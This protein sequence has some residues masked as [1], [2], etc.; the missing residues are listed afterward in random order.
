[1]NIRENLARFVFAFVILVFVLLG[2]IG[3]AQAQ[4]IAPLST[5]KP[6]DRGYGLTVFR[7]VQPEKFEY[8]VKG[9]LDLG[10]EK[11][12]V[13]WLSGGPKING[14]DMLADTNIF[15]GMSGSPIFNQ[16]GKIIGAISRAPQ[17]EKKPIAYATPIEDLV[18]FKPKAFFGP[19]PW[20]EGVSPVG[21]GL[22]SAGDSF[23]WCEIWGDD[24]ACGGGTVTAIDPSNPTFAYTLGHPGNIRTNIMALPFW[25]TEII[26]LIPN[27][28]SSRKIGNRVGPM[29]GSVIFDGPF[30]QILKIGAMPKVIPIKIVTD[31]NLNQK[32]EA[33]I[34]CAY[35]LNMANHISV[36]ILDRKKFIVGHQDID[37]EIRI[38][39]KGL[40][41]IF[42]SGYLGDMTM[43][44]ILADMFIGEEL[45]T[46]I[47]SI[48]VIL[49]PRNKY[50]KLS[51][52]EVKA[53]TLSREGDMLNIEVEIKA[54][55]SPEVGQWEF[56]F[57]A[58]VNKKFI[59]KKI[60]VADG[61]TVLDKIAP[62]L[63]PTK[64]SIELLNKVSDRNPLYLFFT[65]ANISS[66]MPVATFVLNLSE[67]SRKPSITDSIWDDDDSV[68]AKIRDSTLTDADKDKK[69][70]N[71]WQ[72]KDNSSEILHKIDSPVAGYLIK[73]IKEFTVKAEEASTKNN[74]K[75][76]KKKILWLF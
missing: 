58:K 9:I 5:V 61:E 38:S 10:D 76:K 50:E 64:E 33:N 41:Q 45:K 20:V 59:D 39:P 67:N 32:T 22:I 28:M 48:S 54:G 65:D 7:G 27:V 21:Q 57:H 74:N 24:I 3:L 19:N 13:I 14:E 36:A 66:S 53:K 46:G 69:P 2:F 30:G 8:E 70:L 56:T 75:G 68:R 63:K 15:A 1:M 62:S 51:L 44:G 6:G 40:P 23:A 43:A 72:K 31:G 35:T 16:G 34:F 29:L 12:I 26:T 17:G 47:E 73:G 42:S 4:Q 49:R 18:R 71:L 60:Y 37:A 55:G 11:Y 25:R 52:N